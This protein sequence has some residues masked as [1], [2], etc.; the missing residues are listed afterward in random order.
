MILARGRKS[1]IV[2]RGCMGVRLLL[3]G[4]SQ[5]DEAVYSIFTSSPRACA[6]SNIRWKSTTAKMK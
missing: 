4:K 6:D 1:R 5:K 3:R 2:R